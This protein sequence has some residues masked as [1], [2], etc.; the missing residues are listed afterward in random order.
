MPR[1]VARPPAQ[2]LLLTLEWLAFCW[3]SVYKLCNCVYYTHTYNIQPK[4]LTFALAQLL[5]FLFFRLLAILAR[6]MNVQCALI[7]CLRC[8][9]FFFFFFNSTQA[10]STATTTIRILSLLR[11]LYVFSQF[12]SFCWAFYGN[13]MA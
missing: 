10:K 13:G 5:C 3:K 11:M 6:N 1:L 7:I 8:F 2:Q 4:F 12:R 9:F